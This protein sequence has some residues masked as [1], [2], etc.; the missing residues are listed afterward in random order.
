MLNRAGEDVQIPVGNEDTEH[1]LGMEFVQN[2]NGSFVN[3]NLMGKVNADKLRFDFWIK[4]TVFWG[5]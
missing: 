2:F 5:V 3:V 1:P 4:A